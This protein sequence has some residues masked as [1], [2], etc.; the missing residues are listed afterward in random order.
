M[1]LKAAVFQY[2][3]QVKKSNTFEFSIVQSSEGTEMTLTKLPYSKE[4][5]F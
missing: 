5:A 1:F 2:F 3:S 4:F